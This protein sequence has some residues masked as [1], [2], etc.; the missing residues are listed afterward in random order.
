MGEKYVRVVQLIYDNSE[1]GEVEL[2][3]CSRWGWDCI[4]DLL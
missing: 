2:Q 1:N 3:M 4:R